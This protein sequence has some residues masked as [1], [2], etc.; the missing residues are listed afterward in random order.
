MFLHLFLLVTT[1]WCMDAFPSLA[2]QSVVAEK[3]P[4]TSYS[5]HSFHQFENTPFKN[6]T[7]FINS[8][9]EESNGVTFGQIN[10]LNDELR[11]KLL[12]LTHETFFRIFRL[13]LFKQCPFWSGTE[14][15]CMH[16]SCA[17]DTIDD[18]SD[19][20]DVWQPEA[21]GRI[22][23]VTRETPSD[24]SCSDENL[25]YCQLDGIDEDTVYVDLVQNPERFTGYGGDQ[26]FQIWKSIY[27]EN[28]FNRGQDQC[29]EKNFYY[30][31]I[32][33]M[34]ASIST[35]LSNE[36]LNFQTK[37]YEPNLEQFMFRVGDFPDR[38]ENIYLNYIL[39]LKSLI[40]LE[41]LGV[42][43]DL[44]FCEDPEF[45]YKEEALKLEMSDLIQPSYTLGGEDGNGLFDEHG[46]F[47][48]SDSVEVKDEF[49]EN[50]RNV[51]RIMDCVHCDRCRLWGKVQTTGYGTA[52]KVLFDLHDT[53]DASHYSLTKIEL[54]A[55]L[56]TF[57]R[58][59]K[60]IQS[61][62]N[63]KTLYDQAI[64]REEDGTSVDDASF[65]DDGP[66]I[67]KDAPSAPISSAKSDQED[68]D[69]TNPNIYDRAVEDKGQGRYNDI[70][71]NPSSGS[72][73]KQAFK[74]EWDNVFGAV[75]KVLHSYKLFFKV[76]YKY[77][78][79]TVIYY[80]NVFVGRVPE[81][82]DANRLYHN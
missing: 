8:H 61:I 7:A 58:L 2:G 36:Y 78:I 59:S 69:F 81:D 50:F 39:V 45:R 65:S 60:S 43:N 9:I 74:E 66:L 47:Q 57:D 19:L 37:K 49:R 6:Y 5:A 64:I 70:V 35:H 17:V 20:P 16:R 71:Y 79:I 76:V 11:P 38:I 31:L 41:S 25:N 4:Q 56:N 51:S 29:V 34:H 72:S 23:N 10:R 80:W 27:S 26:S 1:C 46:L 22:E 12:Q 48:S 24:D 15:F 21:L 68:I 42:L 55:L 63:F 82:F 3:K 67:S 52:L 13:N 30:K 54:V 40:K 32:S 77:T 73:F 44:E 18:W 75:D 28:C 62:N 33:G 53:S 14:G